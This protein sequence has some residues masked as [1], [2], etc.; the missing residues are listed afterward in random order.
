MTSE[1]TV[2]PPALEPIAPAVAAKHPP[3]W[4]FAI[5][6]IP[7]GVAGSFVGNVMSNLAT[8]AG[9]K[10]SEVG[11]YGGL[12]LVP[13]VLQFMYAPIIDV[14]TSRRR[15]LLTFVA[16]SSAC[17]FAA[18]MMPLPSQITMFLAL[19]FAG[20]VAS[21][22]VGACNGALLAV[23]MPDEVRGQAGAS[24][25]VG[26]LSGGG[27]S[28]AVLIYM[29]GRVSSF[30]MGLTCAAMMILPSL[31]ILWVREPPRIGRTIAQVFSTLFVDLKSALTSKGGVTGLLLCLS[32]V[33]TVSLNTY[34]SGMAV[35]Y[36][37]SDFVVSMITGPANSILT[38]IGA[39][40]G[41]WICDRYNRRAMYLLSGVLTAACAGGMAIA[42]EGPN[43]YA[44]GACV[45]SLITGFAYTA[46]TAT[47]LET[48]GSGG[49][50]AAMRYA[51]FVSA[52]NA[53]ITYVGIVDTRFAIYG[54]PGIC[55]SDAA[56]NVAGV[57]VLGLVFWKLGTFGRARVAKNVGAA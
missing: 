10:M 23:T 28:A 46:F 2:E 47:V 57:V 48:M 15:W 20:Q 49:R 37:A 51:L 22:L 35:D 42:G 9:I 36:H 32:P 29:N 30:T 53:A 7:Y 4:L 41:G 24:L 44:I 34:F 31:A 27:A 54:N 11:W 1:S 13:S 8:K 6:G 3:P 45:Y 18:L 5:A 38:A 17:F 50:D 19:A 12:L 52:G 39:I 16:L 40:G 26:N 21:G 55:A 14:G 33:G 56:L 25:N 43:V